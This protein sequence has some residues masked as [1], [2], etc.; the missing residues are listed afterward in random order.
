M[1]QKMFVMSTEER[2]AFD[3]YA[4]AII[5]SISAKFDFNQLKELTAA[6]ALAAC[7]IAGEMV[8]QRRSEIKAKLG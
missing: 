7:R 8:K 1:K 6:P 4:T 2:K 3:Q 5:R